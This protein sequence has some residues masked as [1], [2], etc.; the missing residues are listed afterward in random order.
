[1]T[2]GKVTMVMWIWSLY[3]SV[4]LDRCITCLVSS[5]SP[6]SYYP[7]HAVKQ[8]FCCVTLIF[9]ERWV[10]LKGCGYDWCFDMQDYRWW[11][12]SFFSSGSTAF[13]L[14][15]FT[16]YYFFYKLSIEGMASC[17]IYFGYT[18]IMVLLF[19]LLTGQLLTI[20]VLLSLNCL[21]AH[22]AS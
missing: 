19:F 18:F 2:Y 9:A 14:F 17:I 16:I 20:S 12:R 5:S 1:M 7:W 4:G 6:S 11:W 8:P 3:T 21:Q 22:L 13:Y 10:G 15:L